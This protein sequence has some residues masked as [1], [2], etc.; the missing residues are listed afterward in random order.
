VNGAGASP[1]RA[2]RA[3][4][5]RALRHR[6]FRLFFGG[7]SVSLIGTWMTRV[8]TAWLVYRL[9]HSALLLGVVGFW[10]QIPT[11]FLTPLGGV[12]VDRWSR[13]RILIVVQT[14][15]MLQSAALAVLTFARII[16]V[17]QI[18]W[19]QA[20]QGVINAFDTPAR[21]AFVVQMVEDRADLPNAIAL[22]SSMVNASRIIGPAIAGALIAAVGEAWC[23]GIDAVSYL[24]V[25][26][27]LFAMRGIASRT[28][29][30]RRRPIEELR[31]GFR[32]V[33]HSEPIRTPLLLLAIVSTMGMPY[34]VLMPAIAADVLHGG[35]HTLGWLMTATGVGAL[36][37]ALYLASRPSV[38]GLGRVMTVATLVFGGALVAFSLSRVFW[39][40]E[41]LLPLVGCGFMVQLAST[42]T[43]LQTIVQE[44]LRGRVMAYFAMAFFGGAPI[45][46]LIAGV[47]ANRIGAP[48]TILLGG[49]VCLLAGAWFAGRLPR[50]RALVRPI[51]VERGIIAAQTVQ[52]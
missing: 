51:Y 13:H 5:T 17:P 38:L 15:S 25:I 30:E 50:L 7:Q 12:V 23:F 44:E 16:T 26:V 39:L 14:L 28:T 24:A 41:L 37:G 33:A 49:V 1:A 4:L 52:S 46:S 40:S 45:G 9:T 35:A 42:N 32:Y 21:Q 10:S 48:Y 2:V 31:E 6:N 29:R 47:V 11:M 20:F 43:I 8:A 34:S 3:Q 27:S 18:L 19:L 22:N 36:G